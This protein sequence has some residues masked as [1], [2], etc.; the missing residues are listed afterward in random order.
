ME[1]IRKTIGR[2][3]NETVERYPN[4]EALVHTDVAVRYNYSLLLWEV[5]R[6]AKGLIK[7]GIEKGDRVALWA[8]N[9]PE[10]IVAML[11]LNKIGALFVPVDPG[12]GQED[13]RYV[14]AQSEAKAIILARGLEYEEYVDMFFSI[15]DK[16]SSLEH[17]FVIATQSYPETVPWTELTA[18]GE[19]VDQ[20][21]LRKREKEI[22]PSDPVAIMYTSGTTGI[23]KGVVLDHLGL[24]NKS[25][26]STRRQGLAQEDKVCL[27]FP[28]YHMFGNTCIALS[29]LLAGATVVMPCLT[30]DP[31]KVLEAIFRHKCTAVYG[32]PSMMIGLL[33]NPVFQKKRFASV[34]KG[35]LGGAPCPM[36]LM[37]K[38]VQQ[39]GVAH[40]TVAYGITEASSW[41]TMTHPGD[42]LE[43]RVTTI[44]VPL[45]CNEVKIV[46]PATGE[47]LKRNQPGELCVRGLLM[48]EYYKMPGLTASVIDKEGWFHTGDMGE[49]NDTGYVKITGRIK[50]V[51]V[52]DGTEIH[53]AELE[54]IFYALPEVSE[55]Q[56]FGFPHPR[57]GQ[58]VAAWIKPRRGA[59]LSVD[60]ITRFAKRKI[61][62]QKIPHYFKLVKAFPM[63]RSGKIQKFKLVETAT[64]EYGKERKVSAP[65]KTAAKK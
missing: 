26:A 53:P 17:T 52:R 7:A 44:G 11:A 2:M 31:P 64:R 20:E 45:E 54:E 1:I 61:E 25:V 49:I 14:L 51:I 23:P 4:Q 33:D 48:K 63:T 65:R 43:L 34:K 13:L 18:S 12:A 30:F 58:E 42:P 40:I 16:V 62:K 6:A 9:I 47:D 19:D 21:I 60:E 24:I 59:K 36:E 5:D 22:R 15:R 29:G 3:L 28:L 56:V 32:S 39:V 57:K 46:H 37:K 35:T 27:F 8:P 38:L 55:V 41:I 10:W 50:D